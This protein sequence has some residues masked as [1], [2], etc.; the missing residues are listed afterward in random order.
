[1]KDLVFPANKKRI[2]NFIQEQAINNPKSY[3]ILPLLE[4]IDEEKEYRNTFEISKAA[5]VVK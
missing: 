5:R 1:L 3:E 4:N 2:I